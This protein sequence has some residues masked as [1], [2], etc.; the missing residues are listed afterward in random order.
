MHPVKAPVPNPPASLY[1]Y[2]GEKHYTTSASFPDYLWVVRRHF[3]KILSFVALCGSA[4]FFISAGITPLYES[5]VTIDVDRQIPAGILGQEAARPAVNDADQFLAT[6]VKLIQSDSVLRPVAREYHLPGASEDA[7]IRLSNLRIARPPN[8]CL[9]L[10]S[11]RSPRARLSAD[12]ANGVARSYVE[13]TYQLRSRS[14][15]S[16]AAFMEKQLDELK[17]KMER[18]SAALARFERELSVVNPEQKNGILSARLLQLNTEYTNAQIDRV[19]KEGAWQSVK[20]GTLEAAQ[21]STQGEALR[22]LLEHLDDVRQKFAEVKIHYGANHPEFRKA[23]AQIEEVESQLRQARDNAS[24]R[25]EV[26]YREALRRENALSRS[27]AETKAEFDRLNARSFEYQALKR[28][29]DADRTLYE[30]LVRKIREAGINAGFENSAIRIADPARMDAKPVYPNTSLT[31]ALALVFSA[32]LGVTVAVFRDQLDGTVRDSRQVSRLFQTDVIGSLPT[33]NGWR[34]RLSL[35]LTGRRNDSRTGRFEDAIRALRN[36][37]VLGVSERPVKSVMITSPSPAEGKT[38]AAVHLAMAH[39]RRQRKT[40]LIDGDLRR[41][42]V[43]EKLGVEAGGGLTTAF[44]NGF[45]W[46]RELIRVAEIPDLDVLPA[47]PS[48]SQAA[49]LIGARLPQI[50]REAATAYDLIVI[51]A[52]PVLGFPEPLEMA[53]AVDGV[54]IVT[55]SGVTSCKAI[56]STLD[57]LGRVRAPVLGIVLNKV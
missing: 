6:Q 49:D 20:S 7:P 21:V 43:S 18:S 37:I 15:A 44:R 3:W 2:D 40:L 13:Q 31:T 39:A 24:R 45:H 14:S 9:L 11:Y 55:K 26:E 8:T 4:A 46:R 23:A 27:I 25:V 36:S 12:V 47:G 19:R 56:E 42:A 33:L 29:A 35:P 53:S 51:D 50:L 5:T 52:T 38:T 10:I 57:T 54:V 1:A 16:L 28:D 30:D 41:P 48:D 34:E 32:L 17:G 22:K